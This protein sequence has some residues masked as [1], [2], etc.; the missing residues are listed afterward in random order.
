[1]F[2]PLTKS[3][4]PGFKGVETR[5]ACYCHKDR[6]ALRLATGQIWLDG[7]S[8]SGASQVLVFVCACLVLMDHMIRA[9]LDWF[10]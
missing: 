1:V 10:F 6:A 3:E 9:H 8:L 4:N 5:Q 2:W 7:T